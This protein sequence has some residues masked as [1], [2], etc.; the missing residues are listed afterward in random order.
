MTTESWKCYRCNLNFKDEDV[1]DM[2]KEISTH[3]VTK[4]KSLVA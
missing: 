3:S 4:V 1:A 2:H